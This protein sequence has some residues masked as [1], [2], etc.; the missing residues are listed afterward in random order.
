[1]IQN[2]EAVSENIDLFNYIKQQKFMHGKS[3]LNKLKKKKEQV[4]N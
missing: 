4:I 3:S 2:S 1:M